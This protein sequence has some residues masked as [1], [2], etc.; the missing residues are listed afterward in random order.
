MFV[1]FKMYPRLSDGLEDNQL[2]VLARALLG[3]KYPFPQRLYRESK[4]INDAWM[5]NLK[6]KKE[7]VMMESFLRGFGKDVSEDLKK[8]WGVKSSQEID[9]TDEI[10]E[11]TKIYQDA[12]AHL[13]KKEEAEL[14][15][16]ESYMKRY[17]Q[18]KDEREKVSDKLKSLL[19]KVNHK[20]CDEC[21]C[22]DDEE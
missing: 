2:S 9:I 20:P 10:I 14:D 13:K 11:L 4:I 3:F 18:V 21:S 16:M 19:D 5:V 15:C 22:E 1:R 17:L 7:N 6:F 12:E 8:Q